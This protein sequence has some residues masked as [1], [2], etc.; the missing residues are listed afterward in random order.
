MTKPVRLVIIFAVIA[1]LILSFFLITSRIKKKADLEREEGNTEVIKITDIA[2]GSV[3]TITLE[4]PNG[5]F[6]FT[7]AGD[8]WQVDPEPPFDIIFTNIDTI[9]RAIRLMT[10]VRVVEESADSLGPYGLSPSLGTVTAD[11]ED[12]TQVVLYIGSMTPARSAYYV[13]KKGVNRVYTI[14][15]YAAEPFLASLNE[16]RQMRLTHIDKETLQ[17]LRIVSDRTMEFVLKDEEKDILTALF[18]SYVMKQPWTNRRGTDTEKFS[19]FIESIPF[20]FTVSE[21]ID[22]DPEDLGVYGLEN[23]EKEFV[24]RDAER[25]LHVLLGNAQEGY[26]FARENLSRPVFTLPSRDLTFMNR[27]PFDL[28][29]KFALI[30][31][32]D[33]VDRIRFTDGSETYTAEIKRKPGD[34]DDEET[35]YYFNNS[36]VE[37]KPFKQF[38]QK[39]IGLLYDAENPEPQTVDDEGRLETLGYPTVTIEYDLNIEP[40]EAVLALYLFNRDFYAAARDGV[41]EFLLSRNQVE[42][43]IDAARNLVTE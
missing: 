27:K 14:R 39:I 32:I 25:E 36:L 17:Y 13:Q 22:D 18:S 15:S 42:T 43:A 5:R 10:A 20:A 16:F 31:N 41:S 34:E 7:K 35:E 21:F 37:E 1:A 9:E 30:I 38:Y 40:G 6:V 19:A 12:G 28:T 23:P 4:N 26:V 29:D 33:F 11:L 2:E 24:L 8:S 3:K